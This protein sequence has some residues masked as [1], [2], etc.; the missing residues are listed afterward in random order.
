[1][2]YA[3]TPHLAPEKYI[4]GGV[5]PTGD[6]YTFIPGISGGYPGGLRKFT[7]VK[8][9]NL[10]ELIKGNEIPCSVDEI[11]GDKLPVYSP[12]GRYVFNEG[13]VAH[14]VN[15]GGGG[16]GDP[17]DRDPLLVL[18]DVK[19]GATALTVA[20]SVYGV[21][22]NSNRQIDYAET[23]K[24]RKRIIQNRLDRGKKLKEGK[25]GV[26][27]LRNFS[28]KRN[29]S[30]YLRISKYEKGSVIQCNKCDYVF[31]DNNENYKLYSLMWEGYGS[32]IGLI[33]DRHPKEGGE[34]I[35]REFYCPGCGTL[36]EVEPTIKGSS[37]FKD[38]ALDFD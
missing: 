29:I 31:C 7:L 12:Q 38:I 8:G 2:D 3:F 1:M 37:I 9:S 15:A 24:T 20:E 17:L 28:R 34:M 13:D 33:A 32:H 5:I 16:Y 14:F 36:I 6:I 35:Y 19:N 11:E 10:P 4:T 23:E 30:E 18:R 27:D 21:I 25:I 26:N 22:F